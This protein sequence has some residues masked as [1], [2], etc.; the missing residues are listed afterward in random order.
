MATLFVRIPDK[1]H[2]RAR[3]AAWKAQLPLSKYVTALLTKSLTR[4]GKK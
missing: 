1:L 2:K 3:D 4:G